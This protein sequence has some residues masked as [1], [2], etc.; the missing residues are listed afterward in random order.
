MRRFLL[1]SVV[2]AVACGSDSTTQPTTASIAGTWN[3]QSINGS[4]MPFILSQT[5]ANKV[6]VVSDAV[7]AVSTGSFTEITTLRSTI[8]GQVTT[9]SVPDAGSYTLN[10]TAVFFIFNSDGSTGTGSL[11]GNTLTVSTNGFAYIYKKQ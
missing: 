3:L 6:E 10:G 11:S 5:G 1:L 9:Q 2:F 8:N 4:N 7:T